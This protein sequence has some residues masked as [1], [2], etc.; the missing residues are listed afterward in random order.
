MVEFYPSITED[1]LK[2]ALDFAS[3][4][5]SISADEQHVII[6]AKQSPLFI[7]EIAWRKRN[8]NTLFAVIMGS[9][10]GAET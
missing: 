3:N 8:S 10:E 9:Y 7:N 4:Y 6:Q 2:L 5:V 1:L